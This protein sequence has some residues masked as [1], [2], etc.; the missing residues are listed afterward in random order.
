MFGNTVRQIKLK[1]SQVSRFTA[2]AAGVDFV[3]RMRWSACK[4]L[5]RSGGRFDLIDNL[6]GLAP[7]RQIDDVP[8]LIA[9]GDKPLRARLIIRRKA[10]EHVE[11]EPKRLRRTAAKSKSDLD[12]RS[13]VAAEFVVLATSPDET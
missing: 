8:I 7:D 10:P 9:G 12:P 4:L 11:A 2:A 13:L 1:L 5:D 6:C 3:V